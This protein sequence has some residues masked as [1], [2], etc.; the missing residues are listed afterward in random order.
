MFIGFETQS[1][2]YTHAH[3]AR[4]SKINWCLM[5]YNYFIDFFVSTVES[6]HVDEVNKVD[7]MRCANLSAYTSQSQCFDRK[8]T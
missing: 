2:M 7:Q 3:A 6:D 1:Q 8:Q 5:F 4:H